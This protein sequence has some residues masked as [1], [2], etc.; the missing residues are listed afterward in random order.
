[1]IF[2][3]ASFSAR[4]DWKKIFIIIAII[5]IVVIS[6]FLLVIPMPVSGDGNFTI[7]VLPDT[8]KYSKHYPEVFLSQTEWIADNIAEMGIKFVIH[9]GDIVDTFD[10]PT[11]WN[12]A[13]I[14][15]SILHGKVPYS[16][17]PGNHDTPTYLYNTFFPVSRFASFPWYG[18]NFSRNDNNYQTFRAGGQDYM[19]ISLAVCPK[20]DAIEWANSVLE[21]NRHRKAILV[22]HGFLN[23]NAERNVHICGDMQYL[24]DDLIAKSPNIFMVLSGHV[25][26]E[27]KRT[28]LVN[29]RNVHQ[30]LADYQ[31]KTRGGQGFLRIMKFSPSEGRIYV[32]TYSP[33][34]DRFE[35]DDDS[36]FVLDY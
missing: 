16:V 34:V 2:N 17:V 23:T 20:D 4:M 7:I 33:Y 28:D 24:W 1:M 8:Q 18:G 11:E 25:S 31:A 22:T 27:A 3:F 36:Q 14:S 21:L 26:G 19:V 35:T 12:A 10:I 13:N 6:A 5:A 9:E 32:S 29:S 30:L 15:M